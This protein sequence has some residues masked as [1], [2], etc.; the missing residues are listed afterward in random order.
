MTL[1][2]R[3]IYKREAIRVKER[4]LNMILLE[5][6][7]QEL[8]KINENNK[9]LIKIKFKQFDSTLAK[10]KKSIERTEYLIKHFGE[11]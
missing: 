7:I 11:R 3:E 1:I 2:T 5:K 9:K 4:N 6:E 8:E 10:I